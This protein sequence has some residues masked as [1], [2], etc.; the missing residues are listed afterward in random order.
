MNINITFGINVRKVRQSLNLSQEKLALDSGIDRSYMSD[1]ENG[2]RNIS[3]QLAE[4]ISKTL[5]KIYLK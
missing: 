2:K 1:I 5:K 3:L 4:K